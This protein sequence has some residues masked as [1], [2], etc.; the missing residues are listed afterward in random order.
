M[1]RIILAA[2]AGALVSGPVWAEVVLYCTDEKGTGIVWKGDR[3]KVK[4]FGL[5]R[6]TVKV[7]SD[8][9]RVAMRNTADRDEKQLG[10]LDLSCSQPMK[11]VLPDLIYC[12]DIGGF[13]NWLFSGNQY[14]R[15]S[16]FGRNIGG[17]GDDIWVSFG[18]CVEF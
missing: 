17:G 3:A 18:T 9:K 1:K 7:L 14:T 13:T 6:Y 12:R 15:S 11:L 10:G 4:E 5:N 16:I 2:L 8:T